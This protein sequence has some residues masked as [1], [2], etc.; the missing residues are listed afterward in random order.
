MLQNGGT[1]FPNLFTECRVMAKIRLEVEK[2]FFQSEAMKI[3]EWA[4][5]QV[6]DK[7]SG[8]NDSAHHHHHHQN[9]ILL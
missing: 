6:A 2:E 3:A 9:L 7:E 4:H 8:A 5:A 1:F